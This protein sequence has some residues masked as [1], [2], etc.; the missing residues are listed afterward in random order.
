MSQTITSSL[1]NSRLIALR[2]E[3]RT[4]ELHYYWVPGTDPHFNEY[5]PDHWRRRQYISGFSGSA[6]DVLIG[7]DHAWLWTDSR[8]WL[9]AEQE[10]ASQDLTL[11]RSGAPEVETVFDWLLQH[12]KQQRV[13]L[14]AGLVTLDQSKRWNA[15][16][17]V[18][19]LVWVEQNLIDAVWRER[20]ALG[21]RQIVSYPVALAGQ[22]TQEKLGAIR[23]SL[24]DAQ[25]DYV[26][27]S[28][29]SE[30]AWLMNLRG[31]LIATTPFFAAYLIVGVDAVSLYVDVDVLTAKAQAQ[32]LDQTV[33]VQPY[34]HFLVA[35]NQLSGVVWLDPKNT[36]VAVLQQLG[37]A[38][39]HDEPSPLLLPKA[40]KNLIEQAGMREAHRLDGL[41]LIKAF[42]ALH[43]QWRDLDEVGVAELLRQCRQ[44]CPRFKGVSFETICGYAD[45]GAIVHYQASVDSAYA[46]GDESCVLIDSGGQ[47]DCGTTD[48]TRVWHFGSPTQE[49]CLH[50]TLVLKGHIAV[51]VAEF[52][53]GTCGITLDRLARAPLAEHGL[54]YGHGTGHGVGCY[55]SVHEGP[56]G[57]SPYSKVKLQAGMVL[58]NEPGVY[59]DGAYG[60]RI[61]NVLLVIEKQGQLAFET[62]TQVPYARN[63]IVIE[64]LTDVE[65]MWVDDYHE[66]LYTQYSA[67]LPVTERQWLFTVTRPL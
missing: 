3:M 45:H 58:S 49:M 51:A 17:S 37:G 28:E 29:L 1:V 33:L 41:A 50:Y 22:S 30:I 2:Q 23:Q 10:M 9:Q 32:L 63:L 35:L 46:L 26:V 67:E 42:A 36:S 39:I 18:G 48:V 56:Q 12:G 54:N 4:Q 21:Q 31:D 57:I 19:E 14:D 53:V 6:G 20:P 52:P 15:F 64:Q 7:L 34:A 5:V 47:Y 61:E 62:L 24:R 59:L 16:E 44:A 40:C 60:I 11:M 13:G 25:C 8:Y 66:K 38:R 65:R 43:Q 55:L 27:V